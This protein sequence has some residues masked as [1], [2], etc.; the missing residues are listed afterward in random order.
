MATVEAADALHTAYQ[1]AKKAGYGLLIYDAYRPQKA[2]N[3]FVAWSSLPEDGKTRAEFYPALQKE[4]LFPL[5]YIALHS[6]HSRGSTVDLTLT[7]NGVPVD[8]GTCFDFMD[9]ASHH[10]YDS[11]NDEQTANRRLL[12]DIMAQAGFKDYENEWWHYTLKDEPYPAT[13]FDFDLDEI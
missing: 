4:Q 10:G 11:L 13:Y 8:M 5:G 1:L 12:K 2:V 9:D 6:G 3:D 7:M